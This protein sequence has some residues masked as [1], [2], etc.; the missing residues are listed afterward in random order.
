MKTSLRLL[1]NLFVLILFS[2]AVHAGDMYAEYQMTGIS[3]IPIVCKIYGKN[4][5]FRTE[6]NMNMG[7]MKVNNTILFLKSNPNVSYTFNSLNKIY[8]ETKTP[9][10]I[11]AKDIVIKVVGNEKVGAYNC[12]H[13]R[14]TSEGK[15]WDAWYTK[16]LPAFNF[17]ISGNN[18]LTSLKVMN[19]LKSKG[20]TGILAKIVFQTPGAN[21]RTISM[22][23]VKF[24]NKTLDASLFSIP[25]GYKKSSITIDPEKIKNMTPEQKKEMMLKMM[26]EQSKH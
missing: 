2:S 11:N 9:T 14:M 18:Q 16:D 24:E 3:N 23:L 26:K 8:T 4:G 13:V 15:S 19:E 6:M 20:I 22:Q 10:N 7:G 1:S 17:P 12:T 5:S 21:A 25:A